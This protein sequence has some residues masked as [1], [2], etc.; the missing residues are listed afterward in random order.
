MSALSGLSPALVSPTAAGGSA[1]GVQPPVTITGLASGLNTDQ[2]IQG[3]LAVQQQQITELQNSQQQV[4]TQQAA[5]KEIEARLLTLQ[6]D[7][8]QLAQPVNGAFD[9]YTATSSAT[10]LVTAAAGAGASPGVYAIQVNSLARA[11]EVAS[12][13]FSS[14]SATITQGTFQLRVGTAATTTITIDGSN[15]TLQGLADAINNAKAGVTAAVVNDGSDP[16]TQPYRL[17]LT[18]SQTGTANA[19]TLTNNLAADNGGA[20]RPVF[21]T[22]TVGPAVTAAS[23][24]GTAV[25]TSGTAA[26]GYTGNAN[27]TYTFTILNSGTVGTDSIQLAYKDST[28]ANTGTITLNAGDAGVAKVVAQGLQVQ[29]SAGT[30]VAGETFTVDAFVPTVQA[31]ADASVTV[32]SGSG[33]L[34]VTSPTDTV[35]GVIPGVTLNLQGADPTQ[36]AT[37]TVSA[38]TSTAQTDIQNFVQGFNDLMQ[39]ID[40]QVQYDPATNTGG[41]LLGDQTV[42]SIQEQVRSIVEGV[43]PG[44]N[45]QMNQLQ[46]LGI[47]VDDNGQLVLDQS[48]LS[49]VL[50]GQVSGVSLQDVRNLFTMAAQSTNPSIQF[51]SGSDKTVASTTPYQVDLSQAATQAS[52]Q[53]TNPLAAST[54]LDSS[55]NTFTISVDGATSS[56]ITL[57]PG[58]YTPLAL[59]QELQAEVNANTALAGRQVTVGLNGNNLTVT[60]ATYG[61]ASRLGGLGGTALAALGFAGTEAGQGQDVVGNYVVNGV[62]E[63][64]VGTGQFLVGDASNANTSGLQVRVTLGPSQITSGPEASLTVTRGVASSLDVLLN[65]LLDPVSGRLKTIDDGFQSQLT[66][67]QQEQQT[68]QNEMDAKRQQLLQQFVSMETAVSQ[69]QT[70]SNALT[71]S[72]ATLPGFTTPVSASPYYNRSPF[73][74]GS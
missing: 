58:T 19:V 57:N 25:P 69:L 56:T 16:R 54:V 72:L 36:P 51:I 2:I 1:S 21:D 64:A 70:I 10:N 49:A 55:N 22:N 46:A 42:T 34:T 43:V 62:V 3:L 35:D 28:G 44:V 20:T 26:G 13:G 7:I 14:A 17:L 5:Y 38:D 40:Q 11:E 73:S 12:Q 50:S 15:D 48:K 41:P 53:A 52:F 37:V 67:L 29:L 33:A 30:L 47:T 60:S 31:A 63:P 71:A 4:T 39:Y 9:G 45:P 8:A 23:F 24:T 27:D 18:S 61:S 59:A 6:N 74:T 32:G 65:N 66:S 68:D